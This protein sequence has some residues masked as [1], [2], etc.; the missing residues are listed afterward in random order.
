MALVLTEG[1]YPGE[2]AAELVSVDYDPLPAVP[3]IEE[4][5]TG[6]TLLFPGTET[7]VLGTG[8][9]GRVDDT[10]FAGCDVVTRADVR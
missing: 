8:T 5:L 1:R 9:A 4:A 10:P 7:N 6:Q 3:G 2:D